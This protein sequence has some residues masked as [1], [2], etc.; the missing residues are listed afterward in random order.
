MELVIRP[1]YHPAKD[2]WTLVHGDDYCSAVPAASLDWLEDLL[3]KQYDIKTQRIGKGKTRSGGEKKQEGQ[4]LN[5]VVRR[6]DDGW[7]L[8]ADLRN[9]ELIIE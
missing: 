5:R 9:A 8:E 1:S 6:T 7:E 2:I 4:V 3:V